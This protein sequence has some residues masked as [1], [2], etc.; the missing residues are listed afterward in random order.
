MMANA[1][2]A[3]RFWVSWR[4]ILDVASGLYTYNGARAAARVIERISELIA[5]P[6][7]PIAI[8]G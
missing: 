8:H 5:M 7:I 1:R 4:S 2:L 6:Q 3:S